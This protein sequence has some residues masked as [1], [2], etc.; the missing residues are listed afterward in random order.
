MPS[1]TKFSVS[2][3]VFHNLI[4]VDTYQNKMSAATVHRSEHE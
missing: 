1:G 2:L 4:K 3:S